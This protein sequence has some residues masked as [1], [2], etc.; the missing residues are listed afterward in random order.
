MDEWDQQSRNLPHFFISQG[1][2]ALLLILVFY[3][4]N[5]ANIHCRRQIF[6]SFYKYYVIKLLNK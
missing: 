4:N 2:Q 6:I 1:P 5:D 3:T